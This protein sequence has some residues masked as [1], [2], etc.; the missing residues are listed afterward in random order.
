VRKRPRAMNVFIVGVVAAMI[1]RIATP[2]PASDPLPRRGYFGVSLEQT[3]SGARV[4]SVAGGST[5]A[6]AGMAAGDMILAID[7]RPTPTMGAVVSSLG[8]H[9]GGDAIS[10]RI[11]RSADIRTMTVTLKAYPAEQMQNAAV[12]YGSVEALPGVR[13]RTITSVPRPPDQAHY[14]AVLFIQGGGCGSIDTPIGPPVGTTALVAAIGAR[15]FVTIR[16]EKS[17]VGDSQGEPCASIGFKDELAGYQAALKAL[18]SHP[19]VDPERV[20]LVTVS[21]G[22]VFAPLL[23]AQTHVAGISVWG[24]PAGPT[25]PY[26]GRSERFFQEFAKVDVAGAWAKVNTRVQVL[27]G[28]YDADPVVSRAAHESIAARINNAHPGSATFREFAGLDHCWT[29]HP[30]LEAS[31]DRCG[32][33]EPTHLLEDEILRF[34]SVR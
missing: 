6:A 14:P 34:L 29:R 12:S 16:V 8:R 7:D 1:P 4:T 17:G 24:T 21:L 22:G 10:I 20:Y 26:P 15:G 9:R 30:S 3:P 11:Q 19:S 13:L 32:Q 2:Q 27:H 5:A 23:A 33:G 31:K 25:P 18:L 28:E